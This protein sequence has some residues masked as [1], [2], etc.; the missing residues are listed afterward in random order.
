MRTVSDILDALGGDGPVAERL[1][2]APNSIRYWRRR[3]RIPSGH[4]S[5]LIAMA[6]TVGAASIGADRLLAVSRPRHRRSLR[7]RET[8]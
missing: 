5:A 2:L 6:Q 1:G 4:W 8:A 3:G 7:S